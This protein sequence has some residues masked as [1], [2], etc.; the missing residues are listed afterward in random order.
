MAA[1]AAPPI[2]SCRG[3]CATRLGLPPPERRVGL[4]AHDFAQAACA[5]EVV[6]IHAE[7]RGGQP[8]VKSRWLWRLETLAKGAG[9]ALPADAT[10]RSPGRGRWTRR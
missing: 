6:L 3:R 8:A 10:T 1:H 7:R 2:P 4:S 5:P 9:V